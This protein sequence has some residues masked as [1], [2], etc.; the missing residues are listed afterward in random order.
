VASLRVY[1]EQG[2]WH[3][4]VCVT[5]VSVRGGNVQTYFSRDQSPLLLP[6][7]PLLVFGHNLTTAECLI[8]DLGSAQRSLQV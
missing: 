8:N 1:R 6:S 4:F 7:W 3:S 5:L 2:A